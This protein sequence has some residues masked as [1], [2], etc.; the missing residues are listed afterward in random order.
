MVTS[1]RTFAGNLIRLFDRRSNGWYE[2]S[3]CGL[4]SDGPDWVRVS[5]NLAE[6]LD[7]LERDA[8]SEARA[9]FD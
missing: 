9:A 1:Q 5:T 2:H 6:R 3:T 7:R 4:L 8:P